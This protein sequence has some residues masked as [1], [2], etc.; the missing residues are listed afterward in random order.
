M[1]KTFKNERVLEFYKQ[2][3]FNIYDNVEEATKNIK[4]NDPIKIY[5]PLKEILNSKKKIDILDVGCGAGWFANSIS[6]FFNRVNE[7]V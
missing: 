7:L 2:L 5:P 3:P 1:I 6:Y 4:K